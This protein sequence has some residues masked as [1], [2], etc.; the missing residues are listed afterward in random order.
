MIRITS[1]AACLAWRCLSSFILFLFFSMSSFDFTCSLSFCMSSDLSFRFWLRIF[2]I[3]CS[4]S[5][6]LPWTCPLYHRWILVAAPLTDSMYSSA[7]GWSEEELVL[8]R[9]T[10]ELCPPLL[11]GGSGGIGLLAAPWPTDLSPWPIDLCSTDSSPSLNSF[12]LALF[13]LG[14]VRFLSVPFCVK[15]EFFLKVD[16]LLYSISG[17]WYEFLAMWFESM[18]FSRCW[19]RD[20]N[21]EVGTMLRWVSAASPPGDRELFSL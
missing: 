21:G 19:V 14:G 1:I 16:E 2:L 12:L 7:T 6:C 20:S 5:L 4:P 17:C 11:N 15:L 13:G 10:P 3:S 8:A 9:G 18:S